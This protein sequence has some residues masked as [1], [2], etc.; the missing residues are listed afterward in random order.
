MA[1]G[2]PPG[3]ASPA[4]VPR[5]ERAAGRGSGG[6]TQAQGAL[7]ELVGGEGA[8]LLQVGLGPIDRAVMEDGLRVLNTFLHVPDAGPD[9]RVRSRSAPAA[10]RGHCST[11]A[12]ELCGRVAMTSCVAE[13]ATL[14]L[15][16]TWGSILHSTGR[17][18][19]CLFAERGCRNGELCRFCHIC[20]SARRTRA[21]EEKRKP[22]HFS[23]RSLR[24]ATAGA[25]ARARGDGAHVAA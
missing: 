19:P 6:C 3:G 20:P 18:R 7:L 1:G 23:W 13:G 5:E 11:H 4:V 17:C 12:A 9:A 8:E 15:G 14:D 21:T 25:R 2:G 22:K 16:P 24:K 10:A